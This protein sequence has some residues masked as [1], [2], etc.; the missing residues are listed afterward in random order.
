MGMASPGPT[1]D[2][3]KTPQDV[4]DNRGHHMDG[5]WHLRNPLHIANKGKV[6]LGHTFAL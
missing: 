1:T 4:M 6:T 3:G 2:I 5:R